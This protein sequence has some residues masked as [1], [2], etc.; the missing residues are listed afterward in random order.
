MAEIQTFFIII[1]YLFCD[2]GKILLDKVL[3]FDY[4]RTMMNI[5][6]I[7]I[8]KALSSEQRLNIFKMLYEWQQSSESGASDST[9]LDDVKEICFTKVY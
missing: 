2:Y 6:L 4:Y 3:L 7:K 1:I 9:D 8:F 5:N